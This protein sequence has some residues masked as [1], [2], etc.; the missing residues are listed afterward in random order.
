MGMTRTDDPTMKAGWRGSW[1]GTIEESAK[2]LSALMGQYLNSGASGL[3]LSRYNWFRLE[4][5][6]T[7]KN[8]KVIDAKSSRPSAPRP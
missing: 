2:R 7:S 4:Q 1:E 3:W 5:E 8:R 6:L